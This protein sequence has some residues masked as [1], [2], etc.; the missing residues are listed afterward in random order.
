MV[1]DLHKPMPLYR[2]IVED[3]ESQ[4]EKGD[5]KPHDKLASQQLL[6]RYYQVS[7]MTIKK[8]L[9]ELN[10]K[11]FIYSRVGKGSYISDRIRKK[12]FDEHMNIGLVLRDLESHFF[13]GILESIEVKASKL[14]CNL[15]MAASG[16]DPNRE[17]AHIGRYLDLGVQGLIIA[18]TSGRSHASK[19]IRQLHT[20]DYPYVVISFMDDNDIN[21]ISVD[22]ELGAYMATEHLIRLGYETIGYINSEIGYDLGEVR[23][24]G[25]L[26]ALNRYDLPY[27]EKFCF[28]VQERDKR[29][30]YDSG[31]KIGLKLYEQKKKPR[32]MFISNDL[33]ALGFEKALLENGIRIPEDIAIVGFDNIERASLASVPLTTIN[34]PTKKIGQLAIQTVINKIEGRPTLNRIILKPEL[35]IRESCGAS[36]CHP[37]KKVTESFKYS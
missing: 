21:M 20:V 5:L 1:L 29:H 22:H 6:A 14:N 7:L 27:L 9:S 4:I 16:N 18:S 31:Y 23:K 13:S 32:A 15:L 10:N 33:A 35:I 2:Q 19:K 36:D 30:D 3:I 8:A 17:D 37:V 26:R 34:Q 12:K 11:Q 28:R 24:A 25:Y